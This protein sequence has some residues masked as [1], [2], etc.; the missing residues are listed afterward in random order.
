MGKFTGINEVNLAVLFLRKIAV[1]NF[2]R[3]DNE[4]S[5][6]LQY[7]HHLNRNSFNFTSGKFGG[8]DS[9]MLCVQSVDGQLSF[10]NQQQ[11]QLEVQLPDFYLPGPVVYSEKTDSVIICNTS[12]EIES[13]SF[14]TLNSLA[15]TGKQQDLTNWVCNIGE[16]AFHMVYH[17]NK[18]PMGR[19]KINS[20]V[21]V[22]DQTMFIIDEETGKILFQKRYDFSPSCIK[23]YHNE[24]G[25][26]IYTAN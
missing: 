13:Y 11:A 23:I 17:A 14:T 3:G 16:Q 19:K 22:G 1:Y 26:E 12:F 9:E 15:A 20:L 7:E 18:N 6:E 21:A 10:F 5:L 2:I 24:R 25:S 4:C 8:A